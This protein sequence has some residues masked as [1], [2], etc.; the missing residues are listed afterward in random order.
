MS[1][2][3]SKCTMTA[4]PCVAA[5]F[6][7]PCRLAALTLTSSYRIPTPELLRSRP[8]FSSSAWFAPVA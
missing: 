1:P 2:S 8:H 4:A 6:R 3:T 5:L 7:P